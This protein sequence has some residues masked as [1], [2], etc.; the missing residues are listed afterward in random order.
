MIFQ[1]LVLDEA[2]RLLEVGFK[3]E[4]DMIVRSCPTPRT[5]M[6]FSATMT[7]IITCVLYD[8]SMT[9]IACNRLSRGPHQALPQQA[10][11]HLRQQENRGKQATT[12]D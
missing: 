2:D 11:P 4:L 1:I 6:L 8:S 10:R 9:Q 12:I 7:G 3:D 5:T